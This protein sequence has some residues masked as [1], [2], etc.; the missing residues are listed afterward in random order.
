MTNTL[1]ISYNTRPKHAF[2]SKMCKFIKGKIIV[3]LKKT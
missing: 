1:Y 2:G 3:N